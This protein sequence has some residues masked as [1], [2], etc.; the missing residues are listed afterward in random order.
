MGREGQSLVL[1][2]PPSPSPIPLGTWCSCPLP[3]PPP[4]P[5]GTKGSL[6]RGW[7][8]LVTRGRGGGGRGRDGGKI[9]V[10]I[11]TELCSLASLLRCTCLMHMLGS[12]D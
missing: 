9:A 3:Q 11:R 8:A 5:L 6:P 12:T 1:L 4:I 2:P 7:A 10:S